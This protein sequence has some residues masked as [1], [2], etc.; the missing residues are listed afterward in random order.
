MLCSSGSPE[1]RTSVSESPRALR[2][3]TLGFLAALGLAAPLLLPAQGATVTNPTYTQEFGVDAGAVF[4]LGSRS[5]MTVN[6]PS[7]R[8]RVGFFLNNNSRWSIE[9][10]AGFAYNKVEDVPFQLSYNLELGALYH[11]R[12]PA[13][14]VE[15]TR[16]TVAYV[17]PFV[18]VVG[19]RTGGTDGG[20]DSELSIGAGYGVK[21]PWRNAM[22][23][24]LEANAGYGFDNEAFRVGLLAG[25]SFFARDVIPTGRR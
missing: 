8:A 23:W 16:A 10:S 3:R 18:G 22:A 2:A 20:G 11:F 25:V 9:P 12:P 24:R 6:L 19:V 4:G 21:I 1:H 17:R 14:V 5:S 7:A 15:A 13:D